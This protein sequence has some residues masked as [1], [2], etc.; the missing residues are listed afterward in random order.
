M[1]GNIIALAMELKQAKRTFRKKSMSSSLNF[2]ASPYLSRYLSGS[3]KLSFARTVTVQDAAG[4]ILNAPARVTIPQA[5]RTQLQ[6]IQRTGQGTVSGNTFTPSLA[7]LQS[8]NQALYYSVD[9]NRTAP[10]AFAILSYLRPGS[11]H[12]SNGTAVDLA[13]IDGNAVDVR[14]QQAALR[15]IVAAINNLAPGNYALGLPRPPRTDAAGA[16]TDSTR[17][18]YMGLYD[19]TT[20]PPQLL[21]QYQNLP[22]DHYF[23][24]PRYNEVY[25][26]GGITGGLNAINN[27]TAKTELRAAIDRARANGA[28]VLHL[29]ADALDHLHIQQI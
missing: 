16:A 15:A 23:L 4:D 10:T 20:S 8:I 25:V 1:P 27:A 24:D 13:I 9:H 18:R 12:H 19:T 3:K 22:R 26:P 11:R 21:P 28:N 5:I 7:I 14:N 6:E 17:Y 29:M 2:S